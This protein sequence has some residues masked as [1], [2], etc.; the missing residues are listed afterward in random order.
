[1]TIQ[2]KQNLVSS[3]KYS[4]KCP[5]SM[6]ATTITVHNTANDASAENEIKYMITNDNQVSFHYAVDDVEVIQGV[7]T[8]RNCWHAGD[9]S[10]ATSGNRTSIAVEIC[11]SKS[12]G[13][14]YT[15]AE[16]L[17]VKFI[18]QL[19]K[20]RGWGVDKLR[21]HYDWSKKDCPHRIRAEKRWDSFVQAVKDELNGSSSGSSSN[22]SNSGSTSNST[23]TGTSLVDYLKSIG[24]DSSLEN[25]KKLAAANGISNYS[26]TS[27]QNTQLL[28]ILRKGGTTSGGSTTTVS[29][30]S[31]PSYSGTSFVDALK[32]I[33]VD[34]SLTN[35]K[36]IASKNGIS[37]YSGAA[38][39]NTKLLSLLK[40]GKL[41]KS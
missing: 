3:S 35:R 9:G 14:K 36:K 8:N 7:P 2:V 33:N 29:Y 5:N 1:M 16:A 15:K 6:T 13:E 26:G 31:K 40:Q 10:G 28:N 12:G 24:V 39:D 38:S 34:S 23:Y 30:Y 11:Y 32:S 21:Q 37:N 17:A 22:S 18:A 19:L 25:R 41:I 20:E 27:A 4:I